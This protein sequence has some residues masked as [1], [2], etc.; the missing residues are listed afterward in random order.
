MTPE[1]IGFAFTSLNILDIMDS[2]VLYY[3]KIYKIK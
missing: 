2:K 3:F 1:K